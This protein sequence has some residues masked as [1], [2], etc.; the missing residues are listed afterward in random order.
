MNGRRERNVEQTMNGDSSHGGLPRRQALAR[1][2]ALGAGA[3]LVGG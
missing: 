3:L 2:A 1:L